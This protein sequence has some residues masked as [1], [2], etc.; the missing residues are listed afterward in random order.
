[1]SIFDDL[2]KARKVEL[3]E[4]HA[5]ERGE[6]FISIDF[7]IIYTLPEGGEEPSLYNLKLEYDGSEY[8][9]AIVTRLD[10][11]N[12][13]CYIYDCEGKLEREIYKFIIEFINNANRQADLINKFMGVKN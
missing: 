2:E 6:N 4:A 12:G 1:M 8:E 11:R 7:G 10:E 9:L 13:I 3:Y 5:V